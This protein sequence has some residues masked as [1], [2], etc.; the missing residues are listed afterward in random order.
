MNLTQT[1]AANSNID[2]TLINAVVR[3]IGGAVSF[4][5]CAQDIANHGIDGGFHGFIY[6]SETVPF[7]RRYRTQI[8]AMAKTMADDL[9]ESSEFELIAGFNCLRD[10]KLD[11]GQV[12]AAIFE[13]HTEYHIEIMNALA[14]FAGEEVARAYANARL[15]AAAPDL[16]AVLVSVEAFAVKAQRDGITMDDTGELLDEVRAALA[17][18][19]S[20]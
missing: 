8:L 14:W 16:Y 7:S 3:Q 10:L 11:A 9:G 18:A 19:E 12:A 15:I 1:I 6:H 5:S 4:K 17:K 2:A 13:R 20:E